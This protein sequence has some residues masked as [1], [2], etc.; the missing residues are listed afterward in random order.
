MLLLLLI[1]LLIR[2]VLPGSHDI[3]RR[4]LRIPDNLPR[5]AHPYQPAIICLQRQLQGQ[6]PGLIPGQKLFDKIHEL[7]TILPGKIKDIHHALREILK[8]Y[9][10]LV[11]EGNP[12]IRLL[13]QIRVKKHD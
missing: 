5:K 9:T 6:I 4:M 10:F 3:F 11:H 2:D 12:R 1:H 8:R 13:R 7:S